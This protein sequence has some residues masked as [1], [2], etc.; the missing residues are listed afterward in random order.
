MI[1]GGQ[2]GMRWVFG[3]DCGGRFQCLGKIDNHHLLFKS[4]TLQDAGSIMTAALAMRNL[5]HR[6]LIYEAD[7]GKTPEP[8]ESPTLRVYEKLRRS[9]IE[10]AGVAGF[11]SIASR[12]LTLAKLESP[13]LGTARVAADGSLKGLSEM[14]AEI[15][16]NKEHASDA[17]VHLIGVL[18]GLLG[19]FL[20]EGLTLSLLRNAWPSEVFDD[21]NAVNGRIA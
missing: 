10:F 20:G 13:I 11:Q 19:M 16:M 14:E 7:V 6:L 9:L 5:A 1:C 15:D 17:G 8:T 3:P 21:G 18:L 12:A 4:A 2:A